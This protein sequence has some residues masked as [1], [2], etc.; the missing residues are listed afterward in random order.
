[1]TIFAFDVAVVASG[2]SSNYEKIADVTQV[3]TMA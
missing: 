2:Y 1:M 3:D